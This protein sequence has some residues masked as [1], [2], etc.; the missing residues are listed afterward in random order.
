MI[1]IKADREGALDAGYRALGERLPAGLSFD[2]F[3]EQL[4]DWRVD[5]FHD[6]ERPVGMLMVRGDEL[7]VAVLPEVRGKWLSR[8]LIR[9]AFAPILEKYGRARTKVA[10]GNA[11]GLD[12]VRRIR[13]GFASLEFD[14]TTALLGAGASL[15]GGFMQADAAQG[16][17]D[18]AAGAS[19]RAADMQMQMFNTQNQQQV[20]WRQ[21]GQNALSQIGFGFGAGAAPSQAQTFA[22]NA[23]AGANAAQWSDPNYRRAFEGFN[24]AHIAQYGVPVPAS[25]DPSVVSDRVQAF[26][27]TPSAAAAAPAAG[28]VDPATGLSSG[29]FNKQ[30]GAND[31]NANLAPN[32]KFALD[33]GIGATK[34]AA[35][36]QTGLLSGNTLKGI[37]DYTLNKSGDLYQQAFNNY[38]ANQSN[39]FNRL[40]TVAGLGSSANQQSAG[41]AG[42]LAPSIANAQIGAGAAQAAGT[43]G[44]ANA[45]SGAGNNALGWYQA[46]KLF[47]PQTGANFASSVGN[48]SG[49]EQWF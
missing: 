48:A 3:R 22:G 5:A 38:T 16:A 47:A 40:S 14:P 8:R 12:F 39:I 44:A 11:V 34:N 17:A 27:Y 32:W 4:T 26:G 15:L 10:E 36:L 7:H 41:L 28:T 49:G 31:L 19:N 2:Q 21:A 1:T 45:L 18:T 24:A 33:Q 30:F 42:S 23:P 29:Y 9:E 6:G 46:S 25:A 20:P 37:A 13:A 35:N 43:V